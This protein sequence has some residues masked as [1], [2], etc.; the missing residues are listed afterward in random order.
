VRELGLHHPRSRKAKFVTVSYKTR[1]MA[2][3]K[4]KTSA[5]DFLVSVL[6]T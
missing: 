3:G 4:D 6:E 1:V 5:E 2:A